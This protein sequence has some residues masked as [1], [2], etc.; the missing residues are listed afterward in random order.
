MKR[1]AWL[2]LCAG[3]P[4]AHAQ[5]L[6]ADRFEDGTLDR[7]RWSA[8]G[9]Y[10]FERDGLLRVETSQTDAGGRVETG[11]ITFDPRRPLRVRRLARLH[12]ANAQMA[13]T[14][15]LVFDGDEGRTLGLAH[16]HYLYD[17]CCGHTVTDGISL[18]WN[19]GHPLVRADKGIRTT[20]RPFVGSWD[21]W[22]EEELVYTP[23]TGSLEY[24]LDGARTLV[25]ASRPMPPRSSARV[26]LQMD[27]W[28]WFTG[29]TLHLDDISVSQ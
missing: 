11:W 17:G 7:S 16:S 23:R 4:V 21:R 12:Y 27:A 3:A 13:S 20:A 25:A 1:L 22:I 8:S 2:L 10:V 6:F 5:V 14:M 19:N 9:A 29:H 18:F 15:R 24:W 26:K 28:G